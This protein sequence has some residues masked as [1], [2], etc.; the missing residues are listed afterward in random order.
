[1]KL[2]SLRNHLVAPPT[3]DR[4][5]SP[6][7]RG[8]TLIELLVVIAIIAILASMLLPA[9][10][11]AKE[12]ARRTSCVNKLKQLNL[13]LRIYMDD[14]GGKFPPRTTGTTPRWPELLRENYMNTKL[15]VCPSD[16]PVP[17]TG[18]ASTGFADGE[19]R[20]YL[21]NGWNDYFEE[22][23]TNF[24]LQGMGG[25]TINESVIP[26][27]VDTI[28]FGEKETESYHYYMDFLE[29]S[30]GNHFEEVEQGRHSSS[31]KGV[32]GSNFSFADSSVRYLRF[33]E[34][35]TPENLWAV[36]DRYRLIN[37]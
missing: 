1:M 17:G 6:T 28:V 20:S 37:Q 18:S 27:P 11:Q 25:M 26:K 34:M 29:G 13:A 24:T 19:P 36:T 12:H 10:G 7:N 5:S 35:I 16:G 21:I 32:G 15:L 8:F 14:Y 9:L 2:K 33:G 22:H 23:M 31:R 30:M 3:P 4:H